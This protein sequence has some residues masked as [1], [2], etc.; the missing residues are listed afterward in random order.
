LQI[1]AVDVQ[2][3]STAAAACTRL[4]LTT[5]CH[6]LSSSCCGHQL[7][8]SEF[9]LPVASGLSGQRWDCS[10]QR[11]QRSARYTRSMHRRA[12]TPQPHSPLASDHSY[13]HDRIHRRMTA[14]RLTCCLKR[15]TNSNC[16]ATGGDHGLKLSQEYRTSIVHTMADSKLRQQRA[17]DSKVDFSSHRARSIFAFRL[18][19]S[20]QRGEVEWVSFVLLY[21]PRRAS[22]RDREVLRGGRLAECAAARASA[23]CR[24]CRLEFSAAVRRFTEPWP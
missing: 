19:S 18:A 6:W 7:H 1:E 9:P 20:A 14:L 16:R 15:K 24:S 10:S 2:R 17:F 11:R 21:V 13:S 22:D 4:A 5:G 12:Q 23:T 3:Q 8:S